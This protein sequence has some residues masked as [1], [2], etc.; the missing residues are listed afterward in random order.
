[1]D[2]AERL[3]KAIAE[4]TAAV[5]RVQEI[6]DEMTDQAARSRSFLEHLGRSLP[7]VDEPD[8]EAFRRSVPDGIKP[9]A[10]KN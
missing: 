7:R 8:E 5:A 9:S 6:L 2:Q 1:M 10:T 3:G 4:A